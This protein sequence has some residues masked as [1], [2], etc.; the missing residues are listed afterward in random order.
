[1]RLLLQRAI[2]G[3]YFVSDIFQNWKKKGAKGDSAL[4]ALQRML[5]THSFMDI[6]LKGRGLIVEQKRFWKQS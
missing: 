5:P 4:D 1:M 6:L 2:I 3:R